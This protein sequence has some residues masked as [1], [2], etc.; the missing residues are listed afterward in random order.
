MKSLQKVTFKGLYDQTEYGLFYYIG[1]ERDYQ[2]LT[3]I[4][5]LVYF[6]CLYLTTSSSR[7]STKVNNLLYDHRP[8]TLT[9]DDCA[10]GAKFRDLPGVVVGHDNVVRRDPTKKKELLPSTGSDKAALSFI[11]ERQLKIKMTR[12]L[13]LPV[14]LSWPKAMLH[15]EQDRV[16]TIRECARLQGFPDYYRFC[17]TV[18]ERYRQ[19]GNAAAVPVGR[20]LGYAVGMAFQKLYGDGPLMTLPPKFSH[21]TNLQLATSLFQKSD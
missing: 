5:F 6:G 8:Y 10:R 18:K 15:P 20:G 9:E 17:G 21:S 13:I 12:R 11:N 3:I 14:F 1:T 16:L 4:V 19:V 2:G 7:G